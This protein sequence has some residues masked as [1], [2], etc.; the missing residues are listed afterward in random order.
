MSTLSSK[1]KVTLD[2]AA[3]DQVGLT[4]V[5]GKVSRA[6]AWTW[7]SGSGAGQA[8]R[9]YT[10]AITI[11][12]GE[13][14]LLNL[15]D[16][17]LT[18]MFGAAIVFTTVRALYLTNGA[19]NDGPILMGGGA[20]NGWPGPLLSSNDGLTVR[21]GGAAVCIA[22]DLQGFVVSAGLTD[23]LRLVNNGT[24]PGTAELILIGTSG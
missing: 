15:G 1:L 5:S 10:A 6:P 19:T 18:D 22:P 9:I 14:T 3:S 23:V 16:G 21:P 12:P 20:T 17:S 4:P 8:D 13:E 7:P 11:P 2:E 24:V